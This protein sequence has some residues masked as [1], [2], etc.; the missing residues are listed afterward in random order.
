MTSLPHS[1]LAR[2]LPGALLVAALAAGAVLADDAEKYTLRYSFQPGEVLRWDVVHRGRV[3][4]TYGGATKATET[5]SKSVKVWRVKEVHDDRSATFEQS[6]EDVDM[7]QKLTGRD[8]I[9]Y[10]SRTDKKPPLGFED[11]AK[12]VGVP[13]ARITLDPRGKTLRRE[14]LV[15]SPTTDN[16]GELTIPLPEEPVAVGETWS[17][18]H[19]LSLPLEQGGVKKI[20]IQQS[21]T[22]VGVKTGVATIEIANRILT[23]VN[24][25]ALE[26]KLIE[27]ESRGTVRFDVDA[28]RILSQQMDVDKRVVG[29]RGPESCLQYLTRSTETLLPEA[30]AVAQRPAG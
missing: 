17:E 4:T 14:N 25:P 21:F 7:W 30:P 23:P 10:N 28:G 1:S 22:L 24:N 13:L 5:V 18:Q 29:F 6:V 27:R 16:E 11:A 3:R 20:L 2:C 19:E 9:R 15:P 12:R 8:E 26:A